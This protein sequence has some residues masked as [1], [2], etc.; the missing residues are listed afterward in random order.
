MGG[1]CNGS[2]LVL[3]PHGSC[4]RSF[5]TIDSKDPCRSPPLVA[6]F[7]GSLFSPKHN[8]IA[9]AIWSGYRL[10]FMNDCFAYASR[11]VYVYECF[12]TLGPHRCLP[13]KGTLGVQLSAEGS[14]L[15]E[16]FFLHQSSG[17]SR[18]AAQYPL[19]C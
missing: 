9:N 14:E 7:I 3:Q 8:H 13:P 1:T 5:G 10:C 15:C 16:F 2:C 19:R 17:D 4:F 11:A 18:C 12:P 6:G